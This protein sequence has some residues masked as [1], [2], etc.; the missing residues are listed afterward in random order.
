MDRTEVYKIVDT[1]RDYQ[2][3]LRKAGRFEDVIHTV[4]E[5]VLMISEY[6]DKARKAWVDNFGNEYGLELVRKIAGMCV[7]CMENHGASPRE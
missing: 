6:A 7:R 2:E 3:K 4:G 5:E 1:E